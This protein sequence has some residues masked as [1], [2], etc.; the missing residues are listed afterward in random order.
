[1]R[2]ILL[3]ACLCFL[4]DLL[5]QGSGFSF[6]YTGP[7]QINVAARGRRNRRWSSIS[8]PGGVVLQ[9]VVSP[10]T[11]GEGCR[12]VHTRVWEALG[13]VL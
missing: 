2:S 7:T 1:M 5:G 8:A 13:G 3:F 11:D 10:A 6:S 12:G 9:S 4:G